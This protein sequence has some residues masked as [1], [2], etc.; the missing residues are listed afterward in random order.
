MAGHSRLTFNLGLRYDFETNPIE[1]HNK[2]YNLT[3]ILTNKDFVN[4]S[5]AFASNIT[6]KNFE[7]R[8]GFADDVFG[9]QKTSIRGGFGIFDDLP[10]EMQIAI[11]YLFNN[12]IYSIETILLPNS[13]NPLGGGGIN[14]TGLPSG[15]QLTDYNTKRNASIMQYN[16]NVQQDLTHGLIL[17]AGYVGS[18]G[19]NLFTGQETNGC[20]PTRTIGSGM[21][22][23]NYASSATCPTPNPA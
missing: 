17:T 9:N 16:L 6:A 14:V 7:P 22:I 12:P 2:L 1:T 8:I 3:N 11:S 21:Y 23:R 18:K 5:H 13:P 15:P 4:V 20:L 19:A 10:L